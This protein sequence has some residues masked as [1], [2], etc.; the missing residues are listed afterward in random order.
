MFLSNELCSLLAKYGRLCQFGK[1]MS[2][3]FLLFLHKFIEVVECVTEGREVKEVG[4]ELVAS[5]K[6]FENFVAVSIIFGIA[7][8]FVSSKSDWLLGHCQSV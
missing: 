6:Q 8:E 2:Y 1:D 3:F 4:D 5:F 7:P